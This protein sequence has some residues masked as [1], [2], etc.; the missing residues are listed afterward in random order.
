MFRPHDK[1]TEGRTVNSS[2]VLNILDSVRM[3]RF[4]KSWTAISGTPKF[5]S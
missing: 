2:C 1:E 5:R 3:R 4:Y